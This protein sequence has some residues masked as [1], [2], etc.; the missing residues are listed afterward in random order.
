[1]KKYQTLVQR[2]IGKLSKG[3]EISEPKPNP[4]A[5]KFEKYIKRYTKSELA[6][7]YNRPVNTLMR[8]INSDEE[9]ICE[10]K[11]SGYHKYQKE[12]KR[13]QVRIIFRHLGEPDFMGE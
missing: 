11:S 9:L 6:A 1:M 5:L 7:L 2:F 3:D 12:F 13:E 10:L 8:W 4:L